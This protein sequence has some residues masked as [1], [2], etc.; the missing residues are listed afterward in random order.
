[1]SGSELE[2]RNSSI[3]FV[4][5]SLPTIS[6]LLLTFA[7]CFVVL[8]LWDF[9]LLLI[10]AVL[11]ALTLQPLLARLINLGLSRNS[12]LGI[13]SLSFLFLFVSFFM[14]LIP[15]LVTE[16]GTL[17]NSMPALRT[18]ILKNT[19][20]ELGFQKALSQ[21]LAAPLNA[22]KM[23]DGILSLGQ[24]AM[25]AGFKVLML[26]VFSLYFLIDGPRAYRWIMPY[27]SAK[28]QK[29]ISRTVDEVLV[30]TSAYV[31]GQ[32]LT[33]VMATVFSFLVLA[34]LGVPATLSLSLI[35][36]IFDI[37][38]VVG[39]FLFTIPAC[40][41]ALTV[42]ST[43][44]LWVL[45]AYTAYHLIE[46]YLIIPKVYGARMRLSALVILIGVFVANSIAGV[47]G[48]IA[49]IPILASYPIVE[50]IWLAKQ[51]GPAALEEHQESASI[52]VL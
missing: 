33:S 28:N 12:S 40:L 20:T 9:I 4:D 46:S 44:A 7:L 6:K 21:I 51:V 10:I 30:V 48:A 24:Y 34:P 25:E 27:F 43:T 39:F 16:I 35:A 11:L 1:M 17:S 52:P 19:P 26:L 23:L 41:L 14:F 49:I 22:D 31:S 42:S 45:L 37:L 15:P 32:L 38:P 5:I 8:K 13:I 18:E 3:L 2:G 36:G 50:R 47:L 29:K